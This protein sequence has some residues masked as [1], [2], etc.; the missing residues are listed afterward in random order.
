[1]A[2]W[3]DFLIS[4][5]RYNDEKTHIE[6]VRVHEDKGDTVGAPVDSVRLTVVSN[7]KGGYSYM[8][9]LKANGNEW[10]K[11]EDVRVIRVGNEDFI[12][13]DA[14]ETASDNLGDLL[15]Y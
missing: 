1:M 4:A 13:T 15:E 3:A 6:R 12:R 5:V 9:I 11:G 14:N 7:I 10:K 8:T 2:K